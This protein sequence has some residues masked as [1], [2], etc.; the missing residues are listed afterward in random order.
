M[1]IIP[2]FHYTI[3]IGLFTL[4]CTG[5]EK[6]STIGV[7]V[8]QE[9]NA[10][11]TDSIYLEV[12]GKAYSKNSVNTI[13]YLNSG[14]DMKYLTA[15]VKG[16]KNWTSDEGRGFYS[17]VDSI[18]FSFGKGFDPGC[19]V[20]FSKGFHAKELNHLGG[21]IW[22]PKDIRKILQKGKQEFAVDAA[23]TNFFDGVS[24]TLVGLGGTGMPA[25]NYRESPEKYN[26]DD[27]TFEIIEA[28]QVTEDNYRIEA[29]FEVN[30]YQGD[31]KLRVTKG[32]LR[33]NIPSQ[34]GNGMPLF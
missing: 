25:F 7:E 11:K 19:R 29:R 28:E 3:A 13:F 15:P 31:R 20:S 34:Y 30:I 5:C 2:L 14:V 6:G 8:E 12:D 24:I 17:P 4:L 18:Y 33:L 27:A 1:K 26:Q 23:N 9:P 32:Y 22:F 16:M 21:D 10:Y